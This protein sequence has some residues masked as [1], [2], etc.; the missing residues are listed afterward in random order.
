[1]SKIYVEIKFKI[2]SVTK[3]FEAQYLEF[4]FDTTFQHF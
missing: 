2:L 4:N 1:M 3:H